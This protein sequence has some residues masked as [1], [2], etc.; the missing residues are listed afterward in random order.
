MKKSKKWIDVNTSILPKISTK[1]GVKIKFSSLGKIR[2]VR[3]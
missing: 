1:D 3:H 2:I